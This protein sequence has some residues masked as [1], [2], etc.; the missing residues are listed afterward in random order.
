[1]APEIVTSAIQ[2][3]DGQ[4]CTMLKNGTL[5]TSHNQVCYQVSN[6]SWIASSTKVLY[7]SPAEMQKIMIAGGILLVAFGTLVYAAYKWVG[8]RRDEFELRKEL[9]DLLA[10][11]QNPDPTEY[12]PLPSGS[13]Q[14]LLYIVGGLVILAG[15]VFMVMP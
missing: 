3:V 11:G 7:Y 2:T 12:A 8:R 4:V 6:G 9:E 14:T 10:A 13:N 15:I 5:I 1:M